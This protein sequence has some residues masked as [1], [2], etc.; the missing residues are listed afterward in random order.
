MSKLRVLSGGFQF[1]I[2][3]MIAMTGVCSSSSA[4]LENGQKIVFLGD[5][6]TAAGARE[7]GY[8]TLFTA[9]LNKVRPDSGI[10][11][12]GAGIGGHR[13]PDLERDSTAMC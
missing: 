13:V 6:I 5:S 8:I 1:P 4:Q 2:L 11:V 9:E 10:E 7:N 12:I 3:L